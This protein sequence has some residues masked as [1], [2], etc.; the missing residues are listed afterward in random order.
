MLAGGGDKQIREILKKAAG[1]KGPARARLLMQILVLAGLRGMV[2]QVQSE[3]RSMG[4][5]IDIRKNPFL[6]KIQQ[7]A[8]EEGEARGEAKGK[9]EAL[10][11][12][13]LQRLEAEFGPLPKWAKDRIAKADAGRLHLWV[14]KS[15]KASGTSIEGIIGKR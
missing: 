15:F 2:G 7:D 9:A 6:L 5:V 1:L 10:A 8:L 14:T 11:G 13:L 12:V 4:V 3:M